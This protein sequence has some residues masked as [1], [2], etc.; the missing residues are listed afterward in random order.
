MNDDQYYE[1]FK[2]IGKIILIKRKE[3]V[4]M[5]PRIYKNNIYKKK[6]FASIYECAA[7][8]GGIGRAV[9]DE[10]IRVDEKLKEM[11]KLRALMPEVGLSKLRRVAG[12]ANKKTENQWAEKV[13]KLSKPALE[14]HISE[15]ANSMPGH[16]KLIEPEKAIYDKEFKDFTAKLD[17]DIILKLKIIKQKMGRGATWNDVFAKLVDLPKPKPQK[18]PKSSNSESRRVSTKEYHEVLAKTNGKCSMPGCNR[19]A[20]EIHHK[21]PWSIFRKH[22]ELEP[23]CKAHHELAH[24]SE[25]DTDKKYRRYKMAKTSLSPP[26]FQV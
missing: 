9:V 6:G 7:K 10:A 15:I 18:N 26:L 24:Q 23:L 17:P 16:R 3:F 2:N 8:L 13:Q 19:P 5:I 4:A 12:I 22:D 11:P 14:T 20:K 21:K 1:K 25:S